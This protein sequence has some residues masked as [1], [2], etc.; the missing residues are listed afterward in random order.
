MT[1]DQ[2]QPQYPLCCGK[3]GKADCKYMLWTLIDS[4]T[5][6]TKKDFASQ[7]EQPHTKQCETCIH[8]KLVGRIP[9]IDE[10]DILHHTPTKS[11]KELIKELGCASH[12]QQEPCPCVDCPHEIDRE[13]NPCPSPGNCNQFECTICC[14][15]CD[16]PELKERFKQH[17]AAIRKEE[18]ERVLKIINDKATL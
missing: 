3:D 8:H 15:H 17:D 9:D 7:R 4:P 10:C 11:E 18:R 12:S 5:Y 1:A 13:N 6:C 14:N 16:S 2:P